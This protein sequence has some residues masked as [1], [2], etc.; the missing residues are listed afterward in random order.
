MAIGTRWAELKKLFRRP[1]LTRMDVVVR[2]PHGDADVTI[3]SAAPTTTLGDVMGA[4]TGQAVPLVV[5][6]DGHPVDASTLLG[7]APVFVGSM[8]ATD[9]PR[10]EPAGV[11]DVNLLQLAGPGAGAVRRLE[12]GRYRIGPGRRLSARE[13]DDA[14]VESPCFELLIED[15]SVIVSPIEHGPAAVTL[16][17]EPLREPSAWTAG[18]L[19]VGRRVFAIEAPARARV[20]RTLGPPDDDGTVAFSRPPRLDPD[21]AAL[22]VV[23]GVRAASGAGPGLWGR[24]PARDRAVE[25]PFGIVDDQ[26]SDAPSRV[27]SIDFDAD[28]AV[29]VV[30]GEEFRTALARTLLLE[31]VTRYGPAD[32]DVVVATAPDRLGTWDW[33][34]WLPHVRL[35]GTPALFSGD[36]ELAAW[37]VAFASHPAAPPGPGRWAGPHVSLL[38]IDDPALWTRRDSPLRELLAAPPAELRIIA[39]GERAE[40]APAVCSAVIT[41]LDPARSSGP[42]DRGPGDRGPGDR[43]TARLDLLTRSRQ[44]R[45]I[46]PALVETDLALLVA[47]S[48]AALGDSE[49]P[50]RQP[51][52]IVDAPVRSLVE[53]LGL[54]GASPA[55]IGARWEADVQPGGERFE[56]PV[57]S[58]DAGVAVTIT[59]APGTSVLISGPSDTDV[60]SVGLSLLYALA[61]SASPSSMPFLHV[62][63]TDSS[64]ITA[65]LAD[66]PHT[67]GRAVA[68]GAGAM[69]RVLVRLE[70]VLES[71]QA[72]VVVID[73]LD[74]HVVPAALVEQLHELGQQFP[75]L[76]LLTLAT[77]NVTTN[78]T[79]PT[80][81]PAV[82]DAHDVQLAIDRRAGRLQ[83]IVRSAA[84]DGGRNGRSF[85]PFE[86]S[87][88]AGRGE[89]R[90]S[91]LVIRPLVFGRA[92]S[93]LERR[94]AVPHSSRRTLE[95]D[96][97]TAALSDAIDGA[98][99]RAGGEVPVLLPRPLPSTVDLVTLLAEHPGDAAPFGLSDAAGRATFD[100][101]WWQPG[102]KGSV[103]M[104]GSPR[105][106]VDA[107][108]SSLLVGISERFSSSDLRIHAV[109]PQPRRVAVIESLPHAG[110]VASPDRLDD[111]IAIIESVA[112]IVHERRSGAA[113][114]H[115]RP[116]V[117]LLVHDVSHLGRRLSA[118][119]HAGAV[120][121]IRTIAGG[122]DVGVNLVATATRPADSMGLVP[123]VADV[124][125]GQMS[126]ADDYAELG[127]DATI[128]SELGA[129]RCW[130]T[131]SAREIQLAVFDRPL[132]DMIGHRDDGGGR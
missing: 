66:L 93:P 113:P 127:L 38:V 99:Q 68:T 132:A 20:E 42:G 28:H 60:A 67:A 43:G 36:H 65:V 105:S 24:R 8:L 101:A 104:I 73:A 25:V 22:L 125:V 76:H 82:V 14:V 41:G 116:D 126:H 30:G 62:T 109:D 111:A 83:G 72:I 87:P 77:S 53:A 31:A 32:L 96:A 124:I 56:L 110:R 21:A 69:E 108:L 57:G 86:P 118:R 120:D 11:D 90:G 44:V 122:G 46:L 35:D 115:D 71:G 9:P 103:L 50:W 70:R 52:A 2:T 79:A 15:G 94:L 58:D 55:T 91:D 89:P 12:G 88:E 47:R 74:G 84:A 114:E 10:P 19:V 117:L 64:I 98:A 39:L 80:L 51:S 107:V 130:S 128:A 123:I 85:H 106:G 131:A 26:P 1:S 33:A 81:T 48:M 3:V 78:A 6:L 37:A 92:L 59:F 45:G 129:H 112:A 18:E 119:H 121:A 27:A 102:P 7:D 34:K 95:L 75:A 54:S 97:T 23:D 29:A 13:L 40:R 16:A 5:E 17:G 4:V 61:A 63:T 49:L 100:V